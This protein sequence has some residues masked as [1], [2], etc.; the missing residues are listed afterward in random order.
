MATAA[1]DDKQENTDVAKS[2]EPSNFESAYAELESIVTTM[3]SG[4][5]TLVDALSA[6]KRGDSLLQFCQKT[7]SDAEQ[8]VKILNENNL[9]E[10]YQS[11]N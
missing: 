2:T 7:L 8:E 9:L 4:Q 10:P 11:D 5:M 6:Y 3:E 1:Q